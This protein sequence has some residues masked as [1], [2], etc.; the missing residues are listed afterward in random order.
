MS[1]IQPWRERSRGE[2]AALIWLAI[3]TVG[4]Y[5]VLVPVHAVLYGVALPVAMLLGAGM[6]AAPLAA[7]V[8][9][10]VAIA[11]FAVSAFL[12]PLV[13][14]PDRDRFW[15]WPW[16]VPA[17]IAL[18]LFVLV[19]TLR[20]GWRLGVLPLAIGVGG[21]LAAPLMLTEAASANA[22]AADLI[23]T[24]SIGAATY[25]VA[26][27]VS[28][29]MRLSRQ[30]RRERELTTIEQQRRVLIEERSRIARDLHD[31]VA[32]SLS[33]I[34]VQSSTARYRIPGLAD[35]V[36]AEFEDIA[37][38]ARGSLT[39]MRRLLGVLRT[40]DQQPQ[41]APRQGIADIPALVESIRR[42]GV[43]V[44][45]SLMPPSREPSAAVQITAY[46]IVQEALSN[47]VRHAPGAGIAVTVGEIPGALV[48]LV[49]NDAVT[50]SAADPG[51]GH[52]LQGMRER[53]AL[54]S[55]TLSA[56]PDPDGG[57]RV[58][59]TLPLEEEPR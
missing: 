6:C 13:I 21:S 37:A 50:V 43:R 39:E 49:S 55:G 10:R 25:L 17:L 9:P 40:D 59:A 19:V 45:L 30:L 52:G 48:I 5:S 11:V 4:L 3:V 44:G 56:G 26:V 29:R 38:T 32:H 35:E 53:V 15:P 24:A 20:H 58:E 33:V 22:A 47:A 46:R 28:G 54:V 36:A 51:S 16:S 2:R 1:V 12:L 42:A 8:Y 18:A 57:W 23:V 41:L 31:V 14:S 34:Q 27:L 7:L